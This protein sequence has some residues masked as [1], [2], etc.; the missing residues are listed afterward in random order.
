MTQTLYQDVVRVTYEYFGPAT[1]RFVT[2]QIR[3]HLDKDP[4]QLREKDLAR[5]IDWIAIA[6]ATL[7]EDQ[8]LITRYITE[9]KNIAKLRV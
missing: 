7:N 3:N 1:D 8:A 4:E 9:L 2:R 5:L 6:M